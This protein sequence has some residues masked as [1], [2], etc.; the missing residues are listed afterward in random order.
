MN[1]KTKKS[2]TFTR[3][4]LRWSVDRSTSERREVTDKTQKTEKYIWNLNQ[5]VMGVLLD[6]S[7]INPNII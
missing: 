3:H 2:N 4:V 6:D 5:T 1:D 7:T